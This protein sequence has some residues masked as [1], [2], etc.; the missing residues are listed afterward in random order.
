MTNDFQNAF[1]D[2]QQLLQQGDIP[3]PV[4]RSRFQSYFNALSA[5]APENPSPAALSDAFSKG[6]CLLRQFNNL[7]IPTK[8]ETPVALDIAELCENL[9][10]CC[11]LLCG[12][13][14][15]RIFCSSDSP[16]MAVCSPRT[17]SW[18]LLNLL[19]NAVLYSAGKYIFLFVQETEK[20][21]VLRV[22]NEGQF[23]RAQFEAAVRKPGSGLHFAE[24]AARAHGGKLL[25]I[26]E[27][28]YTTLALT[29]PKK[30]PDAY[31]L[32]PPESFVDLLSDR[33]SSVYTAF[34]SISTLCF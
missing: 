24:A 29:V 14:E 32:C 20:N 10:F 2:L 23:P 19:S 4:V 11:D 27:P 15:K 5:A 33:L 25:C 16:L 9:S 31:P 3:E 7:Q 13:R 28:H 6:L 1:Y 21:I 18:A 34:C 30:C 8:A 22:S 17:L 26:L 12:P